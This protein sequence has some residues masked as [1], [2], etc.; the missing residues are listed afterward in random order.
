MRKVLRY[1]IAVLAVLLVAIQFLQIERSNPPVNPAS[2]FEA[3]AKPSPE[4]ATVVNRACRDCHSNHTTWPWYSKVAPVSWLVADDVKEGRAHLNFSEWG[5]YSP[6]VSK[7]KLKEACSEVRR[8][9]M[10]LWQYRLVHPQARLTEADVKTIC[11]AA[12]LP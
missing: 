8:G 2:T 10:P 5:N 7:L 11:G 3:V 12:P 1:G 9:D 6:E 4:L